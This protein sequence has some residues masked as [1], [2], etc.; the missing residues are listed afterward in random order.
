MRYAT[1][2]VADVASAASLL[3]QLV[4]SVDDSKVRVLK[5]VYFNPPTRGVQVVLR[6]NE[7][8]ASKFDASLCNNGNHPVRVNETYG[9]N[10]NFAFDVI[11]SS[12]ADLPAS[13]IVF[14]YDVQ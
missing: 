14:G 11:N 13:S 3:N 2:V 7:Y 12:G 4:T 10:I 6:N 5:E 1:A 8:A 9:I